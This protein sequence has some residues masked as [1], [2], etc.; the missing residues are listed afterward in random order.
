M[1]RAI[2]V[3]NDSRVIHARLYGIKG[4]DSAHIELLL[5]KRLDGDKWESLVKPGRD[6][7]KACSGSR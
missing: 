6:L 2:F 7:R 4:E 5:I 1:K 3:V